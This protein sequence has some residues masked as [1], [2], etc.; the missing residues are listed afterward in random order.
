MRTFGVALLLA[1]R[2]LR[3]DGVGLTTQVLALAS[4][5]APLLVLYSLRVG[6]IGTL[7][8][9]LSE[10]P[11][12]RQ[13]VAVQQG[14]YPSAFFDR[15]RSDRRV[16]FAIGHAS[17]IA[18]E[19]DFSKAGGGGLATVMPGI[20]LGTGLG[21][22][23]LPK[24]A[25]VPGP[26]EAVVSPGMAGRLGLAV[27]D[28]V[29]LSAPRRLNG[30]DEVLN[31]KLK[32]T[33]FYDPAILAT[34]G[35]LLAEPTLSAIERWRDGL[36]APE[37]GEGGRA[38][39]QPFA[40]RNFRLY[41]V[42]LAGLRDLTLELQ[43]EGL[44]VQAPRLKEYENIMALNAA[45]GGIFVVIS[46]AGGLGFM[47]SFGANQWGRVASKRRALSLLRL[48]GLP[49]GMAAAFPMAQAV[50]VAV[51]GWTLAVAIYL[52]GAH[53][54]NTGLAA[55]LQLTGAISRLETDHFIVAG[56]LTLAI[57]VLASLLAAWRVMGIEPG[58]GI[59]GS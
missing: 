33:G 35:A 41:A 48:Q 46:A 25:A 10:D 31:L 6:V 19:M 7:V 5:L 12:N 2:D 22:P 20:V 27:G 58:E 44:P 15:L 32:V 38:P 30:R 45:L 40:Y 28:T 9:Q 21:D 52:L 56:G 34:D 23:L 13:I 24:T 49:R 1:W 26:G 36:A 50:A 37:L 11:R 17:P 29:T 39:E 54:L 4:V 51:F 18:R 53:A 42:D 47:L 14:N 16:S 59:H 43:R 57:A 3:R 8:E 55:N